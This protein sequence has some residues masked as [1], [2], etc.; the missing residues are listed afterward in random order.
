MSDSRQVPKGDWRAGCSWHEWRMDFP[1][2]EEAQRAA[3][4]HTREMIAKQGV[5]CPVKVYPSTPWRRLRDWF[6]DHE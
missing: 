2:E 4:V 6:L 1:T 5:T 3:R